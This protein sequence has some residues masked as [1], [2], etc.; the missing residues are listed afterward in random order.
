M[1]T[2]NESLYASIKC[3]VQLIRGGGGSGG[4]G[5][6]SQLL[7]REME[8]IRG[9]QT[10]AYLLKQHK[11][12]LDQRILNLML[13]LVGGSRSGSTEQ[14]PSHLPAVASASL[15]FRDLITDLDVLK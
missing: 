2:D 13:R 8:R 9:Y 12:F 6:G 3:L 10:L 4:G 1:S 5:Q 11:L 7:Q 14:P 15:A